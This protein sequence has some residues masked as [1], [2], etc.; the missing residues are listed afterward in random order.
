VVCCLTGGVT[1]CSLDG[2]CFCRWLCVGCCVLPS[3]M[4]LNIPV[5]CCIVTDFVIGHSLFYDIVNCFPF[6]SINQMNAVCVLVS[7]SFMNTKVVCDVTLCSYVDA[8]KCSW[9][10]LSPCSALQLEAAGFSKMLET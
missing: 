10:V 8:Y 6:H 1:L 7:L 5:C 3:M 2:F 9:V 4:E